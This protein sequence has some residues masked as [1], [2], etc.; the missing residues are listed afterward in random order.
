[1]KEHSMVWVNDTPLSV[2]S[3]AIMKYFIKCGVVS[4]KF[5]GG[6]LR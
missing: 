5:I 4:P 3:N 6:Y 2:K 1:M